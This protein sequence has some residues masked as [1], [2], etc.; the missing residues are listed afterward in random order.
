MEKLSC[1][2]EFIGWKSDD[3]NLEVIDTYDKAACGKIRF[4][5]ICRKCS[6]DTELFPD[7]YFIA[8]KNHLIKGQKP[9]GCAKNHKWTKDQYLVKAKRLAI[10]KFIVLGYSEDFHGQ[11]TKILCKC[12]TDGNIWTTCIRNIINNNS[13]CPQCAKNKRITESNAIQNIIDRITQENLP[14][15]FVSFIG[16]YKNTNSKFKYNC[17]F[18]GTQEMSYTHFIYSKNNCKYCMYEYVGSLKREDITTATNKCISKCER[19]GYIPVGFLEGYRNADSKFSYMCSEHGLKSTHYKH[20]VGKYDVMCPSCS[21]GDYLEQ[22]DFIKNINEACNGS[23]YSFV[24][25]AETYQGSKTKF[26]YL[27]E[28]HGEVRAGYYAFMEGARCKKCWYKN[29][30]VVGGFYG[31]YPER[32]EEQDNLYI[33]NFN[34]EY[35]KIGRAFNLKRRLS[36]LKS[37]SKIQDLTLEFVVTGS[38]EYIF[39][40]EQSIHKKLRKEGLQNKDTPWKTETF[41]TSALP[42][43]LESI[44][45]TLQEETK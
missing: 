19:V 33:V 37:V 1:K 17:A 11:T 30:L 14:Y 21:K 7:G 28:E 41:Y 22:E 38:H 42:N 44:K 34:N 10:G 32:K 3:G 2:H 9:C 27:C 12:L 6:E 26:I 5:V 29:Q 36:S 15:D 20:F 16:N 23:S 18:H 13:G 43:L 25:F 45:S 39:R 24:R 35:I 31:W 8:S 4:K 40:L